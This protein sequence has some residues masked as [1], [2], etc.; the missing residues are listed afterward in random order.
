[1][2]MQTIYAFSYNPAIATGSNTTNTVWRMAYQQPI[3]LY[4]GTENTI[5]IVVFN[6]RQKVVDLTN[7]EI[8]VQ[9]VDRETKEHFVTK[10]A[11]VST[12]ASGVG[13]I[14]FTEADTHYLLNRFY[15]I[16]ARLMPPN[17]GSTISEGEI[18]YLDDNYGAFTPVTIED[19][20]NF[21][22]TSISTVDGIPEITFTNIG[23]TP[24]SYAGFG[25]YYVKVNQTET[26]VEFS[27]ASSDINLLAVTTDIRPATDNTL[28]LGNSS[29][30]WASANIANIRIE[31]GNVSTQTGVNTL[32]LQ[33]NNRHRLSFTDV[34]TGTDPEIGTG[35][36]LKLDDTQHGEGATFETWYGNIADPLDLPG[37]HSLDI[38]AANANSYVEFASHD[39]NHYVGVTDS[40]VFI[41]TNWNDINHRKTWSFVTDGFVVP[42]G[43][44]IGS[45]DTKSQITLGS[46]EFG[47]TVTDNSNVRH[48]WSFKSNG[49]LRAGGSL[50]PNANVAYSLGS[51]NNQW[52]DLWVSNTT[53]YLGGIPLSVNADGNLLVNGN[54]VAGGGGTVTVDV[55]TV[56]TG[57]AGSSASVTNVGNTTNAVFNF[58]IPRG[59]TGPEG[60]RGYAGAKGD[61]GETGAAGAPGA[62]GLKG[63]KGDTGSTGATGAKG[64]KGD[65]GAAGPTGDPGPRGLTGAQ[66]ISVTLQGTKATIADLPLTGNPGDGWIVTTGDGGSHLDGSLWF[67]NVTAGAWN[68]IG[69]IVGP[70]GDVGLPGPRGATGEPGSNGL[71]GAPGAPGANGA[72]GISFIWRSAWDSGTAYSANDVVYYNGSSYIATSANENTPPTNGDYWALLAAKGTASDQDLNTYDTV[73]F[74]NAT[75]TN[76]EDLYGNGPLNQLTFTFAGTTTTPHYI[77]T[78]HNGEPAGNAFDFYTSDGT[79]NSD[80]PVFG[81]SIENG[82]VIARRDI[83]SQGTSDLNLKVFNQAEG[84]TTISLQNRDFDTG[85]KTTQ[86]SV[87]GTDI[88]L[89]TNFSGGTS[90]QWTFGVDGNLTLPDGGI[91]KNADGSQYGVGGGGLSDRITNNGYQLSI[92]SQGLINLPQTTV[93]EYD[94][95]AWLQTTG[96]IRLNANGA[97]WNFSPDNGGTISLPNGGS[98]G[99]YGMGW[100]GFVSNNGYL[101]IVGKSSNQDHLGQ[102]LNQIF[103]AD[104]GNKGTVDIITRDVVADSMST[105][106]FDASGILTLPNNNYL[107]TTNTNLAMGSQ[108]AVIIRSNAATDVG[109]KSW[110]FGTNGNFTLPGSIIA[111]DGRL[112][113][114]CSNS[115]SSIRWVNAGFQNNV[116]GRVY[117]DGG[118][119]YDSTEQPENNERVNFGSREIGPGI[120]SFYINATQ[121]ANGLFNGPPG[122]STDDFQWVFRGDGGLQFPDDTIQTT[123]WQGAAI[124]SDTAPANDL[125]RLWFNSSDARMYVK[126]MGQWVDASPAVIPQA[127]TYTGELEISETTISNTDYTG[128]KDIVIENAGNSW[129]F[130]GTGEVIFPDNTVQTTAYTA[131]PILEIYGGNAGTWLTA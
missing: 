10:T 100:P 131:E 102:E 28:S 77:R 19:A 27:A 76:G 42:V 99:S 20:W 121:N 116:L 106:R 24:N 108:G 79:E 49:S 97:L 33:V 94:S 45:D 23:E 96:A 66:G 130:T 78:R 31:G 73:R 101:S 41:T 69:K 95:S 91:I 120:S 122:S 61:K 117:A 3:T 71:P 18:L 57:A 62:T 81:L 114:D 59:D 111:R 84:G 2:D 129:R 48:D 38:R 127:S 118:V 124:V 56:T 39:W 70:Q 119:P 64:D 13:S 16:V 90:H 26:G 54:L 22:P 44:Y 83:R 63:D 87:T 32:I 7:W 52:K 112:Y 17:D 107:E 55:G 89:T 15:H 72:D 80:N 36:I 53:I 115:Y 40:G 4:K 126:Y 21:N 29:H 14:I 65:T 11:V 109:T 51:I 123:A 68:D 1:M 8:Q 75:F 103:L 6:N 60:P 9:I 43:S 105:W 110:T 37:Q 128:A 93:G 35:A 46:G 47:I 12:P 34:S 88:E 30:R 85:V 67:W 86:L 92:D 58:T 5:K 74:V 82:V 113:Q 50:I 25:G 104:S 125:G 98:I